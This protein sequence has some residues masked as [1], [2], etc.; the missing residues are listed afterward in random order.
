MACVRT[1][2]RAYIE[3]RM[4]RKNVRGHSKS[5]HTSQPSVAVRNGGMGDGVFLSEVVCAPLRGGVHASML[6]DNGWLRQRPAMRLDALP[7]AFVCVFQK[8]TVSS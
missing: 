2:V 1:Y 3:T 8:L 6:V 5:R 4:S 7:N